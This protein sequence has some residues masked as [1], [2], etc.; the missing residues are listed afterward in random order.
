MSKPLFSIITDLHISDVNYEKVIP[1]IIQSIEESVKLGLR[2]VFVGGDV[3]TSRKNQTLRVLNAWHSILDYCKQKKVHLVCIPGNHDKVDYTS[4]DSY[5]DV[6]RDHPNFVLIRDYEDYDL[7]S[8]VRI[9]LI[10]FFDEKST[11][12]KYF[13]QVNL[14]KDGTNYLITHIAMNGVKNNDGSLVEE[15]IAPKQ[16]E[17][18]FDKVFIGHYHDRQQI[19]SNIFYIGSIMQKNYGEDVDKGMTIVNDDQSHRLLKLEFDEF[20]TLDID[21]DTTDINSLSKIAAGVKNES[22]HVRFKI[23]GEKSKI[24]ALDRHQFDNLGID[25]K[26]KY[27][28]ITVSVDYKEA[29]NFSGFDKQ[30]INQ[31][32]DEFCDINKE[33]DQNQGKQYLE[34]AL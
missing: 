23:E 11:Y 9:H 13:E 30:K 31:E 12:S 27:K 6:F 3:F 1:V 28:D 15:S 4:E 5:L 16:F 8:G 17:Q 24:D 34:N 19:G 25:V 33:I 10:P 26:C 32:W 7:V 22:N 18:M 2:T 29:Q 20:I 14:L 21:L